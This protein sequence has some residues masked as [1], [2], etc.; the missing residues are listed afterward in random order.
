MLCNYSYVLTYNSITMTEGTKV[1]IDVQNSLAIRMSLFIQANN[2]TSIKA[3]A[4]SILP[5]Y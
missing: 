3:T 4:S 5:A 2:Y 1:V